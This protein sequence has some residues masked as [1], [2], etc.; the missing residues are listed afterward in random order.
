MDLKHN[1]GQYFTNDE[2]V[3]IVLDKTIK[4][5]NN[6]NNCLEPSYGDGSFVHN[7]KKRKPE[8][9]IDAF[10][11]DK[12]IFSPIKD[13]NCLLNDF[14]FY[15]HKKKYSLIVGNPPYI[16]LV[17]SF[18]SKEYQTKFKKMFFKKGRGRVNLIHA[19]FDTSFNLLE[20]NGIISFLLPSSILT[21]PWYNDIRKTIYDNFSI[22]ELIENIK[23]DGVSIQVCLLVI[24]KET[25]LEKKYIV[26]KG[27]TYQ[28]NANEVQN[29]DCVT[30]KE[31]GF[32]VGVGQYCWSH[33]TDKLN[34]ET[35]GTKLLYSSYI[36]KDSI[37]ENNISNIKKKKY[38][39]IENP[40]ILTNVI[41]FPRTSSK[42]V[43]MVLLIDNTFVLE[44]HVIYIKHENVIKLI[45]LYNYLNLNRKLILDLLNSTNL[46]K[47]E[48]ENLCVK[49]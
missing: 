13:V 10:E 24:K 19:F 49:L 21:S 36:K 20:D 4:H 35:I 46:T 12:E 26:K 14:L 17:Y 1:Y 40:T 48:I 3:N 42:D 32:D 29:S 6:L 47:N 37:V 27:N 22:K 31:S 5:V 41:V 30:I 15:N 11:I 44:N 2:L 8:L 33:Y 34:N 45:E 39:N 7:L 16:E 43:R 25:T 28:I 18:Y 23:F 9:H 38:L